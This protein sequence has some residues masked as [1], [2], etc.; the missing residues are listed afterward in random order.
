MLSF[1][2]TDL[3]ANVTEPKRAQ[4]LSGHASS[5]LIFSKVKNQVFTDGKTGADAE[6]KR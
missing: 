1:Q 3:H 2:G 5:R 4:T 6:H